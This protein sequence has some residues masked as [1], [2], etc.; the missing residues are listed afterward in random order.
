MLIMTHY[1]IGFVVLATAL[2]AL[3]LAPARRYILYILILQILVGGILWWRGGVP[4]PPLH[5][6]LAILSGGVYAMAN[7]FEKR[8]RP[9]GL[10]TGTLVLGFVMFVIIFYL[11]M[12]SV[13]A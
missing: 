4:P 6:I 3:F 2:A 1:A 9:Q 12:K 5:W 11:G 10:V 8:G 13:H 7:A